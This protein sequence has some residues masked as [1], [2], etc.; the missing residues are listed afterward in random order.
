MTVTIL[1]WLTWSRSA[2]F[3]LG[4]AAL[5]SW[6]LS[7]SSFAACTN[8]PGA[9][10]NA[11]NFISNPSSLLGG[12]NGPPTPAEITSAMRDFVAANP[13]ALA[14]AIGLLKGGGLSADQQKAIGSGLGLAAG[15]CIRPDPTFTAEIQTQIA[16][17]DSADAKTAYAAVTGNQLIGSVG[18]GAGSSGSVGGPTNPSGTT[19]TGGSTAL[20]FTSNSVSNIPTNFFTGSA[21][22]AG[23]VGTTTT[24]TTTPIT[25]STTT[26]IT[27]STSTTTTVC[28]VSQTC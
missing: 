15:V 11:S 27:T 12:P 8:D 2:F 18:G 13:Q 1:K 20:A 28:V 23:S 14:A 7:S 6:A 10:Q 16:S 4:L 26:P 25:T 17:T 24:T 3:A 19:P 21:G 9:A 22:G 5:L